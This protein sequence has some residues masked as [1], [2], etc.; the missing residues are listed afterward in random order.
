MT[1]VPGMVRGQPLSFWLILAL[2]VRVWIASY[3]KWTS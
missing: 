1:K 3:R 2:A